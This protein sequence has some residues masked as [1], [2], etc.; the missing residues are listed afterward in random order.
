MQAQGQK[1]DPG[2]HQVTQPITAA[3]AIKPGQVEA[4]MGR[5]SVRGHGGDEKL[6]GGGQK[7]DRHKRR[8]GLLG[9]EP[10]GHGGNQY[11]AQP[12]QGRPGQGLNSQGQEPG[13]EGGIDGQVG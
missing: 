12:R 6:G 5:I 9:P 2:S 1:T 7:H 3:I 8:Q 11:Q 10:A 13:P 4:E